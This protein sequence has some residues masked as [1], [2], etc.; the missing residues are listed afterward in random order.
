MKKIIVLSLALS[1]LVSGCSLAKYNGNGA[2]KAIGTEVAKAQATDFINNYLMGEGAKA[3]IKNVTEE[4]MYKVIV[5]IPST[6]QGGQP[7]EV[8]SYLSADGKKF[9]PQEND[10]EETKK[11]IDDRKAKETATQAQ[12]L[13]EMPKTDKPTVELYVMGFCPYGVQAEATMKPVFDLLGGK[14]DIKVRYIVSLEGNDLKNVQSLHGPLEGM[15]DARQLCVAKNYNQ[16]TLWKYIT[17]IND[18]CYSI[19]RNGED[20]YNKCW[21]DA[22]AKSGVDAKKIE[23][24]LASKGASYIKEESAQ[25]EKNGVSGSPTIIINGKKYE[26]ARTAEAIKTAICGA[27]KNKPTEC[28]QTLGDA[29]GAS[30]SAAANGGCE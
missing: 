30:T 11:M 14:S 27:F 19:Y 20:E 22:A 24:C 3:D 18:K 21:K 8:V 12:N 17:A 28:G 4:K 5:S 23:S 1:L 10:I 15:E 2:A 26:G 6:T 7:Q 9:L 16:K 29:A 25:S 13:T